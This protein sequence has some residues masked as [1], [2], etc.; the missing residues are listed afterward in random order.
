LSGQRERLQKCETPAEMRGSA[1]RLIELARDGLTALDHVPRGERYNPYR[2][3][4]LLVAGELAS[5]A[6][7]LDVLAQ[8]K[9]SFGGESR[10]AATAV[11]LWED[12][13][14]FGED[15]D[16]SGRVRMR[17]AFALIHDGQPKKG[18]AL[19]DE[20]AK[21]RR[22]ERCPQFACHYAR[23]KAMTGQS[24]LA[25]AWLEYAVTS[26][27]VNPSGF[28]DDPHLMPLRKSQPTRFAALVATRP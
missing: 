2:V 11:K 9:G 8:G 17:L 26:C 19:A 18:L 28:R 7:A 3:E 23:L 22:A 25:V 5:T 12:G 6:A 27:G 21:L 13:L 16:P 20:V 10:Y 15:A 4:I 14:R 1:T 24:E